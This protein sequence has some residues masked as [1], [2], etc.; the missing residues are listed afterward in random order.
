MYMWWTFL[1]PYLGWRMPQLDSELRAWSGFM[2]KLRWWL[3]W[4]KASWKRGNVRRLTNGDILNT[5]YTHRKLCHTLKI[6]LG[7]YL[8]YFYVVCVRRSSVLDKKNTCSA[9]EFGQLCILLVPC[10]HFNGLTG[11][12]SLF[13][14]KTSVEQSLHFRAKISTLCILTVTRNPCSTSWSC[15]RLREC[16]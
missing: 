14:T 7:C 9:S 13:N 10:D 12:W 2:P 5:L 4:V 6:W 16:S 8:K 3:G 1:S 11:W 15:T